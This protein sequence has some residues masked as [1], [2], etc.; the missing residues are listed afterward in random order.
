LGELFINSTRR[1]ISD[2]EIP[3]FIADDLLA[4]VKWQGRA[5]GLPV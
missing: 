1:R 5:L 2:D 3:D 4:A